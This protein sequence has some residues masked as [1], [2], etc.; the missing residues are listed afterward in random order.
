MGGQ[1]GVGGHLHVG[2]DSVVGG[3]AGVLK[4]V[5]P[6]IFVSGYPAMPHDEARK[7]HAHMMRIPELK[8]KVAGIEQRLEALEG[9]T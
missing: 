7:A 8:K 3:Q 2:N 5:P 6:A 4:D 1:A 9:K